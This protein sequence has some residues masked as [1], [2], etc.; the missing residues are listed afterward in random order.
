MNRNTPFRLLESFSTSA[1]TPELVRRTVLRFEPLEDRKML[2]A[3]TVYVNDD[4]TDIDNPGGPVQIGDF[5]QSSIGTDGVSVIAEYG[6]D[7]F[8]TVEGST[9]PGAATIYDAIQATSTGGTLNLLGGTYAESDIV[10]DRPMSFIGQG[11]TGATASVIVPEVVSAAVQENFGVGT[12]S[13]IIIYSPT[14][15]IANVRV[16]GAGNGSLAGSYNFHQGITT[17]YDTQNG[18]DYNS[19]HNG[20]LPLIQLGADG[21]GE[22]GA[23]SSIPD[24]SIDNVS[25]SNAYWHGVTIS[26]LQDLA[27]DP[28][29]AENYN[30]QITNSQISDIGDVKDVNRVGVLLQNLTDEDNSMGNARYVT[31]TNAGVGFKSNAYGSSPVFGQ[32]HG[33]TNRSYLRYDTAIDPVVYGFDVNFAD[34]SDSY[35]WHV[36]VSNP[37]NTAVGVHL[38]Y[39]R[40]QL[41][42]AVITGAKIGVEV[43]NAPVAPTGNTVFSGLGWETSITGPAGAPAGSVGSLITSGAGDQY[44]VDTTISPDVAISGFDTGVKIEQ[45]N[46]PASG[47]PNTVIWAGNTYSNGGKTARLSGNT[48]DISV[49]NNAVLSGA[50]NVAG[51]IVTSGNATVDPRMY[52]WNPQS[53]YYY[54]GP[55]NSGNGAAAPANADQWNSGNLTL[56]S[57]STYS[58]LLSGKTASADLFNFNSAA[59]YNFAAPPSDPV[60]GVVAQPYGALYGWYG[61]VTQSGDGVL[62]VTGAPNGDGYEYMFGSNNTP[63]TSGPNAGQYQLVGTDISAMS[64]INLKVMLNPD[65]ESH[66][67]VFGLLDFRGNANAWTVDATQLSSTTWTT[68]SFDLLTPSIDLTGPDSHLD[69][70][71]VAGWVFGGDQ[72]LANDMHTV[73]TSFQVDDIS[74]SS[75]PNSELNVTGTVSLGGAAL[76]VNPQTSP[77][78]GQTWTLVNNDGAD[79]VSGTFSNVGQ[80]SVSYTGGDGNDVVTTLGCICPPPDVRTYLFYNNSAYDAN[81]PGIS[82]SDDAAI[83]TDKT[84][85]NG[86]GTAPTSAFASYSKGINGIMVD[87]LNPPAN[88]SLSDFTFKV[89]TN[90]MPNLWANAPAPTAFSIRPGAGYAGWDRVEIIWADG[91]IANEWLQVVVEGNDAIGGNNTHTGLATSDVFFYANR[92]GDNFLGEPSTLVVTNAGDEIYARTNTGFLLPVTNITDFNKDKFVNAADQIV[93]RTNGGFLTRVINWVPPAAPV[94][95]PTLATSSND[96]TSSAVVSALAVQRQS[97]LDPPTRSPR[98]STLGSSGT[99]P[100]RNTHHATT[101]ALRSSEDLERLVASAVEPYDAPALESSLD[102]LLADAGKNKSAKSLL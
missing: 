5:V 44:G 102:D 52:N 89:G 35:G 67:F 98:N 12:H 4:W 94:A 18:G 2:V 15:N 79:A 16:D 25:V 36:S 10:I 69:L 53:P 76:N 17:L 1:P 19:L 81:T 51:S 8:G 65:N 47:R 86:V 83:A 45:P 73:P 21:S 93:A 82:A 92:I 62:N 71:N 59:T 78:V 22:G 11:T 101:H 63:I 26:A 95:S 66:A 77:T 84:P 29:S 38:N 49:G 27:F 54:D 91:A 96:G 9:Q 37:A 90:N 60:D 99:V 57:S 28:G 39:A 32:N 46:M 24:I 48:T 34:R 87:I 43:Q 41:V 40:S 97:K 31:V 75:V 23:G 33:A 100:N 85:F 88:L 61:H 70:T 30:L 6:F 13:G 64:Q 50:A 80:F 58:A 14:V 20:L 56:G 72:G 7:A 55:G 68:L 74:V 3:T 42:G